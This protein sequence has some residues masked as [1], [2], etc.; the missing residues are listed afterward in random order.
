MRPDRTHH[1]DVVEFV[2]PERLRDA[3]RLKDAD[4]IRVDIEEP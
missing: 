4:P 3:L 2:A 1:R